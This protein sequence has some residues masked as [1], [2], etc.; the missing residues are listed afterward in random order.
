MSPCPYRTPGTFEGKFGDPQL[1]VRLPYHQLGF[2]VHEFAGGHPMSQVGLAGILRW[3]V[4]RYRV[5]G[6][7]GR[8]PAAGIPSPL[9]AEAQIWRR[10]KTHLTD[11]ALSFTPTV[12]GQ[13]PAPL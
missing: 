12:D 9:P 3:V 6:G 10:G 7:C 2:H 1:R 13:H 4:W 11:H 5:G 8:F